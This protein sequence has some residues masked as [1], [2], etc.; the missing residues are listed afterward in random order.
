MWMKTRP[1]PPK[2]SRLE[3][4]IAYGNTYT[5]FFSLS[6]SSLAFT[7]VANANNYFFFT[8]FSFSSIFIKN[9]G[10]KPFTSK[11]QSTSNYSARRP[12]DKSV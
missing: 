10:V 6:T 8:F 1:T 11:Y 3:R 12:Y 7:L 4:R 9:S 2:F 5:T